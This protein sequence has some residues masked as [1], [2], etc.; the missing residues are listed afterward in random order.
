MKIRNP[1]RAALLVCCRTFAVGIL[2]FLA[3]GFVLERE[4]NAWGL[5]GRS[6]ASQSGSPPRGWLGRVKRSIF[7]KPKPKV[8]PQPPVKSPEQ[9]LQNAKKIAEEAKKSHQGSIERLRLRK[10]DLAAKKTAISPRSRGAARNNVPQF[11]INQLLSKPNPTGE[12]LKILNRSLPR[13]PTTR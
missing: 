7:G 5:F 9:A 6:S 10:A 12:D 4:V 3:V 13:A 2:L 8:A 11:K 1:D